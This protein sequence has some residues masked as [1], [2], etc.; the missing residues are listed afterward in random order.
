MAPLIAATRTVYVIL[1]S[2][3]L[4]RCWFVVWH[5]DSAATP[6]V[7]YQK[8]STTQLGNQQAEGTGCHQPGIEVLTAYLMVFGRMPLLC[9]NSFTI[10][11]NSDG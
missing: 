3:S 2:V 1:N 6:V 5:S 4:R 10:P 8:R 7:L 11:R 9:T